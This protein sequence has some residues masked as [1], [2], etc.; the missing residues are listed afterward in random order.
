MAT[1]LYRPAASCVSPLSVRARGGSEK[2]NWV[3]PIMLLS[4]ISLKSAEA[5]PP[6]SKK[7]H[8]MFEG[9]TS[10]EALI[11]ENRMVILSSSRPS[12]VRFSANT[13]GGTASVKS[14]EF[15]LYACIYD[16]K[17]KDLL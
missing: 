8:R 1:S 12:R 11:M 10:G 15:C 3:D 6:S 16:T 17:C 14:G 9:S 5:F 13:T 4:V 7:N 2:D